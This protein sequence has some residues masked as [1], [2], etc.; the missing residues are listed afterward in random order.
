MIVPPSPFA[1]TRRF[2]R[3]LTGGALFALQA[4]IAVSWVAEPVGP[5]RLDTHAEDYGTRHLGL[6]NE[7]TCLACAVR[8]MHAVPAS[9]PDIVEPAPIVR[10]AE[11]GTRERGPAPRPSGTRHSRAPPAA[12]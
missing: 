7:S 11:P 5:V 8:A 1:S 9:S 10:R 4:L 3:R 2:A 12:R 6:H